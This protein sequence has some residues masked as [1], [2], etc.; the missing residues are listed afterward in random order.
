M[1]EVTPL[2][3]VQLAVSDE[4][5]GEPTVNPVGGG[6]ANVREAEVDA[7]LVPSVFVAVTVTE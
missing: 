7:T 6:I 2:T 4:D 3:S 5:V 1:Y